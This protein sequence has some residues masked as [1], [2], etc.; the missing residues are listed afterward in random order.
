MAARPGSARHWA[1]GVGGRAVGL[2]RR[3]IDR[4]RC[5]RLTRLPRSA[6]SSCALPVACRPCRSAAVCITAAIHSCGCGTS[7]VR[8]RWMNPFDSC[9]IDRRCSLHQSARSCVAQCTYPYWTGHGWRCMRGTRGRYAGAACAGH[10]AVG[11]A[12]AARG[13]SV[14]QCIVNPTQCGHQVLA[15]LSA[16]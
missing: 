16:T 15:L 13:A 8:A 6:Y 7:T 2:H 9:A 11:D 5:V 10:R 1:G 3:R 4:R 14:G 12:P